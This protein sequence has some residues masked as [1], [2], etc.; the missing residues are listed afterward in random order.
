MPL[1]SLVNTQIFLPSSVTSLCNL[2]RLS[3]NHWWFC[4]LL[5][6]VVITYAK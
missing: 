2:Q 6:C 4:T 1:Q 5:G 3:K